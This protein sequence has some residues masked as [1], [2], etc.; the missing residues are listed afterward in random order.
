MMLANFGGKQ[1]IKQPDAPWC[2]VAIHPSIMMHFDV[3]GWIAD[4][5][6][7]CAW[8]WI[9]RKPSLEIIKNG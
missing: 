1:G 7:C 6:R 3:M 5:E 2:A 8:A 9:T 4:F